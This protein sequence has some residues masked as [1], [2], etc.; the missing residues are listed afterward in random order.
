VAPDVRGNH[1]D[2]I[3]IALAW[4]NQVASAAELV[5]VVMKT[6]LPEALTGSMN[7]DADNVGGIWKWFV[8]QVNRT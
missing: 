7:A 6:T 2:T 8:R 1:A 3:A 4:I 5:P